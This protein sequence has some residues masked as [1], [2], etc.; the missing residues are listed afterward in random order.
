MRTPE[1]AP[2]SGDFRLLPAVLAGGLFSVL[3]MGLFSFAIP[4][5]SLDAGID[6]AR[7]GGAF[8]ACYLAKLAVSPLADRAVDR[9]GPRPVLLAAA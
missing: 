6:G 8:A 4:L 5:I 9:H 2:R 3:G 1:P 7:L